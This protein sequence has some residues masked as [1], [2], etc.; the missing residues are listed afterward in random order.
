MDVR[1]LFLSICFLDIYLL[2]FSGIA[3]YHLIKTRRTNIK[4]LGPHL[5]FHNSSLSSIQ[6]YRL[7]VMSMIL[8]IWGLS[9]IAFYIRLSNSSGPLPLP[10]WKAI[11]AND[12]SVVEIPTALMSPDLIVE[13]VALWYSL[14]GAGY[15]YFL[16]LARAEK[17]F[18]SITGSGFGSEPEYSENQHQ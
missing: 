18:P 15:I 4:I 17:F 6:Y 3:L 11:H 12:S 9:W 5:K 10:S 1:R 7:M 8:G 13:N 2:S 14:P 16:L